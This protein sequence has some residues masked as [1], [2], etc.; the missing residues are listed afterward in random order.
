MSEFEDIKRKNINYSYIRV[1]QTVN[2]FGSNDPQQ[3]F[4]ELKYSITTAFE[5]APKYGLTFDNDILLQFKS[6]IKK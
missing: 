2:W 6:N 5:N 1:C 3:K 4:D